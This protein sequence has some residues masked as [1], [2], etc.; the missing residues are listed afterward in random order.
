[1]LKLH[2]CIRG[3]KQVHISAHSQLSHLPQVTCWFIWESRPF[4]TQQKYNIFTSEVKDFRLGF[5]TQNNYLFWAQI[6]SNMSIRSFQYIISCRLRH[7]NWN[8]QYAWLS[9]TDDPRM[10]AGQWRCSPQLLH[11]SAVQT[12]SPKHSHQPGPPQSLV[13]YKVDRGLCFME[14]YSFQGFND[15]T[16]DINPPC[17]SL[18]GLPHFLTGYHR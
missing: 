11:L 4:Y 16:V 5:A 10:D 12:P 15:P 6:C 1:M 9:F 13:S 14:P 2:T 17:L 18:S 3:R 8:H 7:T